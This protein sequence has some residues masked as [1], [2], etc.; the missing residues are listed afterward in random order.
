MRLRQQEVLYM[1]HLF[2]SDGLKPDPAKVEAI[3]KMSRPEDGEGVQ[4]LN[5]F[6]KYLAKFLPKL[7]DVME[8]IRRLTR[9]DTPWQWSDKQD[10]ALQ[11]IQHMVTEAPV[12]SYYN[13]C[14]ELTVQCDASQTGLGAAL[15][16]NDRPIEY[17]SRALTEKEKRYAQIE[18]KKCWLSFSLSND[19][20]SILLAAMSV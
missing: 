9:K 19:L 4:R 3:N 8:P 15:L 1:V 7:S 16:Q 13:P 5:C 17:A 10:S 11:K 12:L 18:K 6:V 2:S 20:T 14:S